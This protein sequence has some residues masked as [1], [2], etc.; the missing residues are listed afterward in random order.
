MA[1]IDWP[2]GRYRLTRK[3]Y[4]RPSPG[5]MQQVLDAGTEIVYRGMPGSNLEPLDDAARTAV[6]M[7]GQVRDAKRRKREEVV[8]ALRQAT[9][10]AQQPVEITAGDIAGADSL[11]DADPDEDDGEAPKPRRGRPPKA[12]ATE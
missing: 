5:R 11:G 3:S 8:G 6:E 1:A 10:L 12:P 7:A 2:L 9:A 4:I